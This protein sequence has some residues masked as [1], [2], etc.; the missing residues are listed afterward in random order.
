MSD[1]LKVIGWEGLYLYKCE[2][3]F[4]NGQTF[5]V[6]MSKL[7]SGATIKSLRV[8][9]NTA[10]TSGNPV[11]VM[12]P[13][14]CNIVIFDSQYRLIPT[15]SSSPFY[16]YM[17]NGVRVNLFISEDL[18]K[19]W[20]PYGEYYTEGWKVRRVDGGYEA[21]DLSCTDKLSYIGNKDIPKLSAYAGVNVKDL[22]REIFLSIG[23]TENEFYIDPSLSLNMI[24]AITKG[25]K[26]R[27]VLNTIAQSLIARITVGRNGVVRVIPAFPQMD[28]VGILNPIGVESLNIAHNQLAVYNKVKLTYNKVDDRPSEVLLTLNNVKINKGLNVLNNL[29]VSKNI[30]SVDGV[31]IEFYGNNDDLNIDRVEY[32]NYNASQ[33]GIDIEIYSNIDKPFY[34]KL[35]VEGR[36]TGLTD[37]YVEKDIAD[38]DPK[39][40]NVLSLESYVIQD[41]DVAR[42][43]VNKVA[44]YLYKMEQEITITGLINPLLEPGKYIRIEYGDI[45]SDGNYLITQFGINVNESYSANATLIKVRG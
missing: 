19:T 21:V 18:G 44:D 33:R 7:D 22:L 43:Y 27:E 31:Y 30:L 34:C 39:V 45:A 8:N 25:S 36:S 28:I 13:N 9:E 26:L 37:A 11:G 38:T 1:Q 12:S 35:V 40:G 5:V 15:N 6:D 29:Q 23:L 10:V 4:D 20:K 41:E 2:L 14:S 17:R 42:D 3:K 32:I 24:Y 16:G